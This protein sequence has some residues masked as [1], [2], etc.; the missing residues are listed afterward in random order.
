MVS[1][2]QCSLGGPTR[3]PTTVAGALLRLHEEFAGCVC[4]GVSPGHKHDTS[5]GRAADGSHRARRLQTYP[6]RM[7]AAIAS[8]IAATLEDFES[9]GWGAAGWQRGEHAIPRT[10][11]FS[12]VSAD[13]PAVAIRNEDVLKGQNVL[14]SD[15]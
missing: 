7:C 3:K 6:P 4:P 11:G 14:L 9:S 13:R 1:F 12:E 5:W 2:E 15:N 8:C 10:G